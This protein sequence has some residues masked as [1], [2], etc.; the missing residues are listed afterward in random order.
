MNSEY[1]RKLLESVKDGNTTIDEA[2]LELKSFPL[3][4]WALSR[5]TTTGI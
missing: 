1:L 3:R 2:M 5:L 4:I